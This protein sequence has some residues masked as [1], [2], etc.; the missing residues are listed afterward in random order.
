MQERIITKAHELFMHYGIR[1]VS[2]DEL[3]SHLGIS[4]KTIYQY[5]ADK[6]ALVDGVVD[7]EINFYERECKCQQ[8]KA[9]NAI[10]EMFLALDMT[11]EMITKMNPSILYDLEKYH[12][13]AFTKF[14]E[15]KNKFL[16]KIIKDNLERGIE[17][18][19]YRSEV[20]TDILS[21]FRI[22]SMFLVF[23]PELFPTGK[24]NLS[25]LV[26]ELTENFLFGLA[27]AK[28]TKLIQKYKQQ[29][30]KM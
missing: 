1:S 23:N 3:A 13:K 25:V 16:Y 11:Q 21:R 12:P 20:N 14:S 8:T 29:R 19:L 27:T 5:Y 28:G 18:E 7:I 4:K 17:E 30:L 2:M 10:H 24:Y 15:H 22:I 9:E 26:G 6:D